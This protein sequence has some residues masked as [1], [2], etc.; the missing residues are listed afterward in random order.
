MLFMILA[1]YL[2]LSKEDGDMVDESNSIT[3]QRLILRK[4]CGA[5]T[6]ICGF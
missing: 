4:F 5:K 6:G 2:R 1:L 3:N